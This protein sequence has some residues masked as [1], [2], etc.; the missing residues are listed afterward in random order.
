MAPKRGTKRESSSKESASKVQ[1]RES[2]SPKKDAGDDKGK[3]V[4]ATSI[5]KK[6]LSDEIRALAYPDIQSGHGEI[7]WPAGS[8]KKQP[9]SSGSGK[10]G[11]GKKEGKIRNYATPD[12][13]PFEQLVC[14]VLLS[15]PIS[16]K[17]GLRSIQTLLSPPFSLTTPKAMADVGLEGRR[18][19]LWEART[20]HKE[21]T[22]SQLGD[23]VDGL[24]TIT[25]SN[26]E[27]SAIKIR[28][29]QKEAEKAASHAEAVEKT[30]HL[31]TSNIKGLG[32]TGVDIFLRQ[33]QRQPGWESIFPFIDDR[34]LKLAARYG[35]VGE[36]KDAEEGAKELAKLVDNDSQ[37]MVKLLDV[38]IGIDLEKKTD[39]TL[40][41]VCA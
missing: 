12:L 7:D 3:G 13:S 28:A 1:K 29:V 23:L 25:G 10:A 36:G 24:R 14:A 22:A 33:V 2:T 31:L 34:A 19:A 41:E 30:R 26:D 40:K 4:D 8:G 6:L 27:E 11:N 15:K 37:K 35:L 16:H 32:P 5:V 38:L 18:E 9:P 21:K 39:E 17:L 20:Q